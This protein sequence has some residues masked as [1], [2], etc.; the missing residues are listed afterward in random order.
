[1]EA[2]AENRNWTLVADAR[3]RTSAEVRF[4]HLEE[5]L[6]RLERPR[7]PEAG[8]AVSETGVPQ[9]A[10]RLEALESEKTRLQ[11][12]I[13]HLEAQAREHAE[14]VRTVHGHLDRLGAHVESGFARLTPQ[15]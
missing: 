15:G 6:A 7:E 14:Y 1:M 3:L 13:T 9:V 11:D 2:S 10:A 4:A 8:P 5:R 12:R